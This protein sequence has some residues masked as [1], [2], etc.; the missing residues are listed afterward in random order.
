M[1]LLNRFNLRPFALKLSQKE[2]KILM[3]I[4]E[5]P[6]RFFINDST[7]KTIAEIKYLSSPDGKVFNI[8]HTFVAESLRGQGIAH[9]L[10]EQVVNLAQEKSAKIIPSCTYA[11]A[12]FAANPAYQKLAARD[13]NFEEKNES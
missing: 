9:Q 3:K 13:F 11:K 6:G 7:G 8:V 5:E 1:K 4:L 12:A 2:R 10:L